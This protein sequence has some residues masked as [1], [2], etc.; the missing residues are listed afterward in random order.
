[1]AKEKKILQH[2]TLPS[3][4]DQESARENEAT[5]RQLQELLLVVLPEDGKSKVGGL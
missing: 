1:M 3:I 5:E 2:Y 4:W